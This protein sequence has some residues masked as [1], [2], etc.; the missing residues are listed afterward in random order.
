[1]PLT[2]DRPKCMVS[3]LGRPLLAYLLGSL[4]K[5]GVDDVLIVTGYRADQVVAPG[6]RFV[7][8]PDYMKTNMV[9]SLF[10]ASAYLN[11]DD[12]V[13]VCYSDTIFEPRVI[14]AVI[15]ETDGDIVV[16]SDECWYQLW[17][18]RMADPLADAETFRVSPSGNLLEVGRR[19]RAIEEIQG[20]YM[21][22]IKIRRRAILELQ[23]IYAGLDRD[24]AYEGRSFDQMFMTAFIQLL[25]DRGWPVKVAPTCG[26][27]LEVD[28][29]SDLRYYEQCAAD[30]TLS[31]F[32]NLDSMN[33]E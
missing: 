1:M 7:R 10:H 4:K 13:L 21:G 16:G 17:S 9:A 5:A 30:G 22:L 11:G 26:G 14:S 29:L 28:S 12:D 3:L 24:L 27:W 15:A 33:V 19:P 8:N 23:R 18:Q 25:I 20:Q 31:S 2:A 32:C 6:C